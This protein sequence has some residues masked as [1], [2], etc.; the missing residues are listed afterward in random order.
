[1]G[2]SD[3]CSAWTL[4]NLVKQPWTQQKPVADDSHGAAC[5]LL[6]HYHIA[7]NMVS[8]LFGALVGKGEL[9]GSRWLCEVAPVHT[10]M[11]ISSHR[12]ESVVSPASSACHHLDADIW[13]CRESSTSVKVFRNFKDSGS[14]RPSLLAEGISGGALLSVRSNEAVVFYD[15]ATS[16]VLPS[17]LSAWQAKHD[18]TDRAACSK[19][20]LM[21]PVLSGIILLLRHF[22][23]GFVHLN[24]PTSIH[25][26][27]FPRAADAASDDDWSLQYES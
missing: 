8:G 23:T 4:K 1:M 24:K 26:A 10:T 20:S 7:L 19:S 6:P 21:Y 11:T 22:D 18:L 2:W 9:I 25:R 16:K 3:I 12:I 13:D 5:N 27:A 14:I 15:W 17:L